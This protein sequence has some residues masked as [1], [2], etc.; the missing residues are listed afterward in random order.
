V[1]SSGTLPTLPGGTSFAPNTA[2][3]YERVDALISYEQLRWAVKLNVKNV[4]NKLYF[5]SV[6]DNGG[7]T[8]PGLRRTVIVT[9][10][11]KY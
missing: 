4:F 11:F 8:V 1:P 3:A 5:D 9:A 10:E 6:Y 2:P 7:F